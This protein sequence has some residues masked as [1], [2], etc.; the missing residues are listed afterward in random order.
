MDGI[1]NTVH[2]TS[3][4]SHLI[5]P[6]TGQGWLWNLVGCFE[7]SSSNLVKFFRIFSRDLDPEIQKDSRPGVDGIWNTVH[8][9][10]PT[11]HRPGNDVFLAPPFVLVSLPLGPAPVAQL[12]AS[13]RAQLWSSHWPVTVDGA[14]G[15]GGPLPP[16]R[17]YQLKEGRRTGSYRRHTG[18]WRR[19]APAGAPRLERHGD[20]WWEDL[21][22][23]TIEPND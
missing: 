6:S 18:R 9:P 13:R 1:W 16:C 15:M 3:R 8:P 7:I 10:S 22:K 19:T 4:F 17:A 21:S 12:G 11:N 23:Q 5:S 2:P 14:S 20:W